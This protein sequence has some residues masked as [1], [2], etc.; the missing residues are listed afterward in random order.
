MDTSERVRWVLAWVC[1]VS[2]SASR[3]KILNAL[4]YGGFIR[5][6]GQVTAMSLSGVP[7]SDRQLRMA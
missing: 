5:A 1:W 2:T 4:F 3:A 6:R 7:D